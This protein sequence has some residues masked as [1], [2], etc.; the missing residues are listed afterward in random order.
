[1][2]MKR[3]KKN[4]TIMPQRRD[5]VVETDFVDIVVGA[6]LALIFIGIIWGI[7]STMPFLPIWV[8]LIIIGMIGIIIMWIFAHLRG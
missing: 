6:F 2:M 4:C 1:M 7:S 8:L 3:Y 5:S